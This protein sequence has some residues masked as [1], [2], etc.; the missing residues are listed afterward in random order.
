MRIPADQFELLATSME[1]VEAGQRDLLELMSLMEPGSPML[2]AITELSNR[3]ASMARALTAS[4][5]QPVERLY[6]GLGSIVGQTAQNCGKQVQ[7]L[8]EGGSIMFDREVIDGLRDPLLHIVRNALSHGIE[9]PGVRRAAGKP[10]TGTLQISASVEGE[11]L[12]VSIADDGA[13]LDEVALRAAG[14]ANGLVGL[15]IAD[16]L[17]SPG[18]STATEVTALSGRGVGLDAVAQ[19]ITLLGGSVAYESGVKQGMKVTLIAPSRRRAAH[20]A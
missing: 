13:G 12:V 8:L 2:P 18:I 3:I 10:E 7:L 5:Q 11:D 14:L 6:A 16:I 9:A 4:S 15:P 19:R 20:A 17:Q 1:E